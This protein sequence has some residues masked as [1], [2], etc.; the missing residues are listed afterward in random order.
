MPRESAFSAVS[1]S[2]ASSP[3]E[4]ERLA[5]DNMP[6]ATFLALEKA[7]TAQHVDIDDLLSA[8]RW[9]LA[10]A[11]LTY[12]PERGI[13]FG[14]FARSQITWAML[15][16][17]RRA[18]PAGERARDKIELIRTAADAVRTRTGR[19]AT[20]AE[21]SR[22]S[23]LDASVV[24]EMLQIDDMVRTA[25]SFEEHFDPASGR[26]ATDLTDSVILP[27]HAAEQ[28]ETRG[29][30]V[31]IL[32]AL[33][34]ATRRVIR[35]I[36]LDDRMVKDIAEEMG[37]SHAYVSKL[38]SRGLALMREAMEAWERGEAGDRSNAA[39]A[40]FFAA[41]LGPVP[42]AAPK[43]ARAQPELAPL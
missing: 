5:R 10:R 28:T 21:L 30:L 43:A 20:P 35:G 3:A 15:S 31:R 32:D 12:E 22:E 19:D 11:A 41:V 40:D 26:Q 9:G 23:G 7:R 18:D 27:E 1:G 17:M 14:A 4:A 16:D 24:A 38:R 36:Y 39:R 6:L 37:V 25:T 42:T 33:P 34:E 13:P 2:R 8:A 29:M